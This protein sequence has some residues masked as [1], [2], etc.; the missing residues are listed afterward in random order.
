VQRLGT[1]SVVAYDRSLRRISVFDLAG[2]LGRTTNLEGPGGTLRPTAMGVL[3]DGTV[4]VR[5]NSY[6]TPSTVSD[7]LNTV[8]GWLLRYSP[9]GHRGDTIAAAPPV[10]WFAFANGPRRVIAIQP[11]G[12]Q[13]IV[14]VAATRVYLGHTSAFEVATYDASGVIERLVRVLRPA[15]EVTEEDIRVYRDAMLEQATTDEQRSFE[16]NMIEAA[17][18]PEIFPAFRSIVVDEGRLWVEDYRVPGDTVVTYSVFGLQGE[19]LGVV[20]VPP[21]LLIYEIGGDYVLGRWKD[22]LDVEHIRLHEL[23][24]P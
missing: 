16:R 17:P 11:F 12:H 18:F 5:A 9:D 24:K 19:L 7:G 23:I 6:V 13:A 10:S 21:G 4:I 8:D 2:N 1:D 22:E 15:R 20:A 3:D 14:A